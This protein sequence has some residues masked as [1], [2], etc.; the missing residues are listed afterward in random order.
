[1]ILFIINAIS[2]EM[3]SFFQRFLVELAG[4]PLGIS[5]FL[6]LGCSFIGGLVGGLGGLNGVFVGRIVKHRLETSKR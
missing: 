1:M 3:L 2:T 5:F 6:F 4:L